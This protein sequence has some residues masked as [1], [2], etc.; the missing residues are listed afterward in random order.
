[1]AN[2]TNDE[3]DGMDIGQ[4]RDLV[5]D[6]KEEVDGVVRGAESMSR[7]FGGTLTKIGSTENLFKSM[8][9]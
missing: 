6:L 9:L 5:K 4:L 3:I 8:G 7:A 1:M 2:P